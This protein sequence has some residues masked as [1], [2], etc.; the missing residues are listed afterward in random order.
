MTANAKLKYVF[1]G[2]LMTKSNLGEYPN[3][4]SE[5]VKNNIIF[6]IFLKESKFFNICVKPITINSKKD[7]KLTQGTATISSPLVSMESF[8]L[9]SQK[10][11]TQTSTSLS[12]LTNYNKKASM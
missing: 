7:K 6:S 9:L 1:L 11:I 2:N 10:I 3:K 12:Y 5:E 4:E 8:T